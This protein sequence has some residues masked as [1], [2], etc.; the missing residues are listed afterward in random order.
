MIKNAVPE[1]VLEVM[2]T[3][4]G[5]EIIESI[6]CRL[7][8]H[9]VLSAD[10]LCE[11][12]LEDCFKTALMVMKVHRDKARGQLETVRFLYGVAQEESLTEF[13]FSSDALD[14]LLISMALRPREC[15]IQYYGCG[16]LVSLLMRQ[17]PHPALYCGEAVVVL[18]N[19]M[20]NHSNEMKVAN[21]AMSGIWLLA[22]LS[23]PA[24]DKTTAK[25]LV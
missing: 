24:E 10:Q 14:L 22:Q 19:A 17:T 1:F 6:G 15:G 3:N 11:E 21:A 8:M 2:K 5:V 9:F 4:A 23:S 18:A 20:H 25:I 16:A 13:F 12:V 7:L